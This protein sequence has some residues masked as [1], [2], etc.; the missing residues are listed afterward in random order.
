MDLVEVE[1]RAP[2][3]DRTSDPVVIGRRRPRFAWLSA[4]QVALAAGAL[5]VVV[6]GVL[7]LWSRSPLWLDEAQAVAIARLPLA[8]LFEALRQD[9]APPLYYLLLHGWIR[10]FGTGT[11]AVRM[12]SSCLALAALPLAWRAGVLVGGRRTG[13]AALVLFATSPF[14]VRYA[15]ETRMYALVLLLVLAGL[16]LVLDPVRPRPVGRLAAIAAVT[17]ALVLTHYWSFFLL[18]AV[19]AVV[20]WR[21][22]ADRRDRDSAALVGAMVVG[23]LAFVPWLPSFWYQLQHTGNPWGSPPGMAAVELAIRG[24]AGG[25][26]DPARLLEVVL[27]GIAGSLL[28]STWTGGRGRRSPARAIGAA[29]LATLVLGALALMVTGDAFASRH[30]GVALPLFLVAVAAGISSLEPSRARVVVLATTATLGL[31]AT[32]LSVVPPRTQAGDIA[33]VLHRQAAPGDVVVTCPDQ[34]TPAL[35]RML[36]GTEIQAFPGGSPIDRLDWRDY[37]ARARAADPLA[38]AASAD[39]KAGAGSV[40]LVWSPAYAGIGHQCGR[41]HR[42]LLRLRPEGGTVLRRKPWLL[43]NAVLWRGPAGPGQ[44][45]AGAAGG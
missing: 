35:S 20:F 40:W 29:A 19:G 4:R 8:E 28:L 24:Y 18:A 12:L 39:A 7:R 30:A 14:A 23:G 27:A 44:L 17:A 43:E 22:I 1:R 36:P 3:D 38:L 15:T 31:I 37:R 5:A 6:G 41:L 45:S 13:A 9:A 25:D 33:A 21:A 11:T 42:E 2:V 26:S 16:V 34:L 10:L 32:L